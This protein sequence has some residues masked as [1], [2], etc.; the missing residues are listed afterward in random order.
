MKAARQVLTYC[1]H[2]LYV[3]A[4]TGLPAL[5][6]APDTAASGMPDAF[7]SRH[8]LRCHDAKTQE[9]QLRIDTL[10]RDFASL[11]AAA[12]WAEVMTRINAGEMPPEEE[13]RPT[14]D[15]IADV[16][17]WISG[18]IEAGEASRMA[19]RGPVA[20]YRLS[21]E[22]Y[23]HTIDDLL[24]VRIDPALP[25]GLL[26]DSRWHGFERVGA[27]LTLAPAHVER[28]L[29]MADDVL[30]LAFPEKE[31]T[32]TTRRVDALLMNRENHPPTPT[33]A[34]RLAKV[35]LTPE[36][37]RIPAWAGHPGVPLWKDWWWGARQPGV[38]RG[39]VQ[40]SG[41][42]GLDGRAPH[43][44][45]RE[46]RND[47]TCFDQDIITGEDKTIIIEIE[48]DESAGEIAIHNVVHGG[49]DGHG[50]NAI[51]FGSLFT[52]SRNMQLMSPYGMKLTTEDGRALLPLLL[53][54]W[55][56]WEGPIVS[57]GQRLARK[58]FYPATLDDQEQIRDCLHRFAEQAW[59]RPVADGDIAP[60]AA[61]AAA[62][63]AAGETPRKA[64]LSAMAAVLASKNFYFLEEG[65]ATERRD[66]VTDHELASRLSYFLWSSLPDE[67][68]FAAARGGRL[69]ERAVLAEQLS[70]MQSDPKFDRFMKEFPRQWLQLHRVGMFQPDVKLYPQYD[71][72]L[73]KSMV[74][75]TVATFRQMVEENLPLREF[76]DSNWTM[77]NP[78]LAEHY[79]LQPPATGDFTKV[80]LRPEDHRGGLLTQAAVLSLSSDGTRHRPVHRGV[81]VSEAIF[82]T[83]PPPPPPNVEP[84]PATKADAE[85]ATVRSQLA[86]HST[87]AA[88]AACHRKID[89]LGLAFDNY[90]AIGRYRTHEKLTVGKGADPAVD[91]SG[92]LPD[93]RAF[94]GPEAFKKLL[95]ADVDRVAEAFVGSLATYA[96]R[97]TMTIDDRDEIRAIVAKAKADDYRMRTLFETFILSDL[98]Q[99]R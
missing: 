47:R 58:N 57:E 30:E 52:S 31:P 97:R 9:G 32:P 56:E 83:T 34:E 99:K 85:K 38:W 6:A 4:M 76:F 15:E 43:A 91:A 89:P 63:R 77:I 40:L 64:Y 1:L 96:L 95:A 94:E 51:R 93:G 19:A 36:Q 65:S 69:H 53:V 61:L 80:T 26:D 54:D 98:F 3:A 2:S 27:V 66:R 81:W 68:L 84:L 18:R 90:D 55:V 42:P 24:G 49:L 7:L 48:R 45:V 87:N 8:C 75:E 23:A 21:R 73:E 78:R 35:G 88:C 92:V 41:M 16:V 74:L 59:R 62:E 33:M 71:R 22:E 39:R 46:S 20:S 13:T 14:A 86:A 67:P 29:K 12:K 5:G 50:S 72:W 44:T 11:S 60:Y 82:G 79:G 17:G 37:L 70:R 10:S 28:Y 25:G